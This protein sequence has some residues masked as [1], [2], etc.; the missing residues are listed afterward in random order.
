[1][2]YVQFGAMGVGVNVAEGVRV[3]VAVNVIEA[4]KVAVGVAV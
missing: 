1:M 4:V 3:A 2:L